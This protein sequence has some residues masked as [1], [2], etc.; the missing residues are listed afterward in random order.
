MDTTGLVF[1]LEWCSWKHRCTSWRS[2]CLG[3]GVLTQLSRCPWRGERV[4]C[5]VLC[6]SQ[7]ILVKL[8]KCPVLLMVE[9]RLLASVCFSADCSRQFLILCRTVS[10]ELVIRLWCRWKISP[11]NPLKFA[12]PLHFD[13]TSYWS[14]LSKMHYLLELWL[15]KLPCCWLLQQ[16]LSLR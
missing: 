10:F 2:S 12:V 7:P 15:F 6:Q 9:M 8:L 5:L 14:N 1:G 16:S 4:R 11:A 3:Y 13:V